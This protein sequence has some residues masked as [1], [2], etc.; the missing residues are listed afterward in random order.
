MK[1]LLIVDDYFPHSIKIAAKMIHELALHLKEIGHDAWIITPDPMQEQTLIIKKL[2]DINILYFKSGEIKNISKTKRAI[3]ETLLSWKAWKA[4]KDFFINN[5][6]DG[7]IYYSP[8]I[9]W[10]PLVRK[11]SLL[12]NC[13]TYLVLRDIFP[14]WIVDNGLVHRYSPVYGYF[15]FFEWLNYHYADKIGVNSIS[16]IKYFQN[17]KRN[18]TKF[19]VLYN[20]SDIPK[21]RKNKN[22]FRQK[23]NLVGKIVFF[24]GG[25]IGHAQHMIQLT[26]LAKKIL[27]YKKVH[28]LIVGKGDEVNLILNEKKKYNLTNLTYLTSVKQSTYFEML[29]EFD[30][31]LFSLH[32]DHK[33]HNFPGKLLG[34]MAFSKPIL[35]CVN[36]GNDL[37]DVINSAG[38]GIIVNSGDEEDLF[39]SAKRLIDSK[40]LRKQMGQNGKKLLLEKFSVNNASKQILEVL[41]G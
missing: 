31:G 30:I 7:I 11:L 1:I 25:N 35:G 14:Q 37:K 4:G 34:Y 3:N 12:W 5:K 10:A 23:L 18:T 32:P 40:N 17:K 19:E 13:R 8:T 29:E 26:N 9:F 16:N 27:D 24:F 39:F 36:K 15:K 22:S 6:F 38:A 28:F 20:W 21:I 2:D 33:T 41:N